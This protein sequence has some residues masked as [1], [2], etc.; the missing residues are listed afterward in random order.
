[1]LDFG[2][3]SLEHEVPEAHFLQL[4][5]LE[6]LLLGVVGQQLVGD[7]PPSLAVLCSFGHLRQE[8]VEGHPQ[9]LTLLQLLFQ[10]GLQSSSRGTYS[11][12]FVLRGG[13]GGLGGGGGGA[14]KEGGYKGGAGR[15]G[16][17]RARGHRQIGREWGGVGWGEMGCGGV[18]YKRGVF[19]QQ[20]VLSASSVFQVFL[21]L[22][23]HNISIGCSKLLL[24]QLLSLL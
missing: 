24:L 3:L 5:V 8:V 7:G 20:A 18:G 23:Q 16:Q 13:E 12:L 14:G 4:G 21:E 1:M 10:A 11:L 6:G 22:R 2:Q 19:C 17:R 9:L 15:Q